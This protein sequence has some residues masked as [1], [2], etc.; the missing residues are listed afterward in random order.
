[1]VRARLSSSAPA[2]HADRTHA[3]RTPAS[4]SPPLQPRPQL[5]F[6]D[7]RSRQA[8]LSRLDAQ[9]T[10]LGALPW[11]CEHITILPTEIDGLQA[12]VT[13][14]FHHVD[15]TAWLR[16]F[17]A[18][19]ALAPYRHMQPPARQDGDPYGEPTT[20]RLY[21]ALLARLHARVRDA[22]GPEEV[23]R[24]SMLALQLFSDKSLV[25]ARGLRGG[26]DMGAP[27]AAELLRN[28]PPIVSARVCHQCRMSRC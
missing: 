19:A 26:R 11:V 12:A 28:S 9:A 5:A 15:Q 13:V 22:Q 10:D 1:M 24:T 2:C 23:Q 6:H 8:Y 20:G 27:R 14:P 3:D 17:V 18:D 25:S 4:P 21:S 7:H 16:A